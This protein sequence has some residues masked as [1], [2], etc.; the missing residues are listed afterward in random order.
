MS[1]AVETVLLAA[2]VMGSAGVW[3]QSPPAASLIEALR[4]NGALVTALGDRGGLRGY[5]VAPRRGEAYALYVTVDGHA[6]AGLLYRPDG[7][8]VTG[9]QLEALSAASTEA[10]PKAQRTHGRALAPVYEGTLEVRDP[11]ELDRAV[12]LQAAYGTGEAFEAQ[13]LPA[14]LGPQASAADAGLFDRA[15]AAPGFTLGERGPAAVVFADPRCPFSRSLVA[16]LGEQALAGRLRLRVAPVG[17][18]GADSAER[19]IE[20]VS[21]E[22]PALAWFGAGERGRSSASGA[23]RI[24]AN[25]ALFDAWGEGSVPLTVWRTAEGRVRRWVGDLAAGELDVWVEGLRR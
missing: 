5:W 13:S 22:A 9:A 10:A 20:I 6:V 1:R 25:N 3:A 18:L 12:D 17:L 15:L 19:A 24:E 7:T 14:S 11:N 23:A 8:L 4:A 16:R 21:S 2:A